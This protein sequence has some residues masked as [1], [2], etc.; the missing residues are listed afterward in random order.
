MHIG[1]ESIEILLMNMVLERQI[2]ENTF[3]CLFTWE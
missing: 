1:G 2:Q 3:S